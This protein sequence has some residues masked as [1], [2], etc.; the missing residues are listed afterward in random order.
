M[1]IHQENFAADDA[2]ALA[3]S[4]LDQLEAGGQLDLFLVS[5]QADTLVSITGPDAEPIATAIELPQ[6]TAGLLLDISAQPAFSLVVR[7]GGHYTIN[8]DVVTAAVVQLVAIYRK[9]GVDF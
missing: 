4:S 7:T 3:G 5:T 6:V 1:R 8:I 2:D 9:R